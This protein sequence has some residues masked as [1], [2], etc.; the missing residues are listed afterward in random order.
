[1]V[2]KKLQYLILHQKILESIWILESLDSEDSLVWKNQDHPEI[3]RFVINVRIQ[4]KF[5]QL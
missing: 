3:S 4:S 1:M 2:G 5:P